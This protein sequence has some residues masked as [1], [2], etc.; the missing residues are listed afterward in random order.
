[1]KKKIAS[2]KAPEG[3]AK[4]EVGKIAGKERRRAVRRPLLESFSL[5]VVI[6]KKGGYR[7]KVHDVSDHG[8]GFDLD[9]EGESA[10]DFPT[11]VGDRYALR[12]YLNQ[13]LYIPL[14]VALVRVDP[15]PRQRRVGVE[16]VDRATAGYQAYLAF[17]RM[18]DA[19][20][21]G[22]RMDAESL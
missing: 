15:Q 12:F 19:L 21:E 1:M 11:A 14:Q 13:T 4:S 22:G 7:L 17:L 16:I 6:P 10:S 5:F 18:L 9:T 2:K 3:P 20:H 8:L